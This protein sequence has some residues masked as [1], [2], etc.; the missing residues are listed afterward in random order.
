MDAGANVLNFSNIQ[1]RIYR[2]LQLLENAVR[3]HATVGVSFRAEFSAE[4]SSGIRI[5]V[6]V[7]VGYRRDSC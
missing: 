2:Q 3:V 7:L 5:V 4:L 6:V 1:K